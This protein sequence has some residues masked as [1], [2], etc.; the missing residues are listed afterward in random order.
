MIQIALANGGIQDVLWAL[1]ATSGGNY[2]CYTLTG[3]AM[4]NTLR[5]AWLMPSCSLIANSA[6]YVLVVAGAMARSRG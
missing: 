3:F 6:E 5:F 1:W 2:A 4:G